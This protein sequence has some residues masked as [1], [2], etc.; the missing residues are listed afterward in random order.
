M[1]ALQE[2]HQVSD[3][4]REAFAT[5]LQQANSLGAAQNMTQ[6]LRQELEE[7]AA[8]HEAAQA[9]LASARGR[10]SAFDDSCKH[11]LDRVAALSAALQEAHQAKV[12]SAACFV[13]GTSAPL[14]PYDLFQLWLDASWQSHL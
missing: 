6:K 11:S 5:A 12:S 7:L 1:V 14:S 2:Q 8:S 3:D 13:I 9:E 4:L 10:L